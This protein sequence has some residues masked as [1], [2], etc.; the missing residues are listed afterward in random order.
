MKNN[1]VVLIVFL[2]FI[3]MTSTCL[4]AF[5]DYGTPMITSGKTINDRIEYAK[6]L[7]SFFE[8]IDNQIPSLSPSQKQWLDSELS[9]F[10]KAQNVN[11]FLEITNTKEFNI[12]LAKNDISIVVN[13]LKK[14][15]TES[16]NDNN[17]EMYFWSLVSDNLLKRDFWDDIIVLI[18]DYKIINKN[19]F[20]ADQNKYSNN[21]QRMDTF[22]LNNGMLPAQLILRNILEPYL[23][24]NKY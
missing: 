7:L 18:Y 8:K 24:N 14:I 1:N 9:K 4:T 19:L 3:V 10:N 13:I 21:S 6:S 22:Y 16:E 12:N 23:G 15:V 11:R 17:H 20:K 2:V 5:A